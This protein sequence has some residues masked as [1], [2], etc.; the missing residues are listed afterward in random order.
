MRCRKGQFSMEYMVVTALVLLL[1]VGGVYFLYSGVSGTDKS[2]IEGQLQY[3]GNSLI[4]TADKVYFLGELSKT[5]LTLI[6]PPDLTGI[7]VEGGNELVFSY[8]GERGIEERVFLG[9]VNLAVNVNY[10]GRGKRDVVL[11]S[12]GGY[13][14]ICFL[15]DVCNCDGICQRPDEDALTCPTDCCASPGNPN[16]QGGWTAAC[17]ACNAVGPESKSPYSCS[18]NPPRTRPLSCDGHNGCYCATV[19]NPPGPACT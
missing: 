3:I 16:V 13:V 1:L 7:T 8:K 19:V 6:F 11:Q 17:V 18:T 12:K 9:R 5:T 2:A 10:L 4:D 15:E 14:G